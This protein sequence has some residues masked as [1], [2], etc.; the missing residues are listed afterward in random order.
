MCLASSIVVACGVLGQ[1]ATAAT[2][3]LAGY[4]FENQPAEGEYHLVLSST[5]SHVAELTPGARSVVVHGPSR[6][7]GEP[8]TT[9]ATVT[10]DAWVYK[11]DDPFAAGRIA[12]AGFRAQ[13]A[14]FLRTEVPDLLAI[15]MEYVIDAPAKYDAGNL[16]YAG[17]A[18]YGPLVDGKRQEGSDFNDYLG[19]SWTYFDSSIDKPE[20]AQY[21]A[22]DCSGFT[23]MIYGYRMGWPLES[24]QL[25]G[26]RIPRRAIQIEQH[27]PGATI[28]PNEGRRPASLA[29][30]QPGDLLFWDAD[31]QDAGV[32][33]VG[34][35]LGRD[36]LGWQRFVSSRK[37]VNGPT[38]GDHGGFSV[39]DRPGSLYSESFRSA[40]RI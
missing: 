9:Q 31:P 14:G 10:T 16:R 28:I 4:Q 29:R 37:T 38:M 19:V 30:L 23:R 6:V 26:E 5:G 34:F 27:A 8:N 24:Q 15:A 3:P 18:D 17:D 35:F 33:H 40:K 36:S 7:F 13:L 1:P 22:L 21:G 39:L 20:T 2:D 25:T 32:D 11:L 12:D